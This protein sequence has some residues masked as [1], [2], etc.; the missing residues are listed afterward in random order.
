MA[1]GGADIAGLPTYS[2]GSG[3]ALRP[4]PDDVLCRDCG[5]IAP[6]YYTISEEPPP[7]LPLRKGEEQ[8][9]LSPL[10]AKEEQRALSPLLAKEGLGEVTSYE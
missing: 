7:G 3:V 6:P 1:C 4:Q 8:R 10:L 5:Q 2:V 9:A